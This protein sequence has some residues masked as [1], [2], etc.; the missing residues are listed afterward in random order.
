VAMT[1]L[2][3]FRTSSAV[4][5]KMPATMP[6]AAKPYTSYDVLKA[7]AAAEPYG[8]PYAV[9]AAPSFRPQRHA[10]A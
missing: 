2:Q 3:I 1:K 5:N 10:T 4:Q 7:K 8:L 6:Q 9:Q